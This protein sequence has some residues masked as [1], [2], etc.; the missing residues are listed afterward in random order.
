MSLNGLKK[1]I[2]FASL[3]GK[4]LIDAL[5]NDAATANGRTVSAALEYH[6]LYEPLLPQNKN[7]ASWI[8]MMYQDQKSIG[9]VI[10]ECMSFFAANPRNCSVNDFA[11]IL[12][13]CRFWG[14]DTETKLPD[15]YALSY[16]NT[17][18]D[19]LVEFMQQTAETTDDIY[20]KTDLLRE[21]K[22]M[23]KL[24]TDATEQM[25]EAGVTI[26]SLYFFEVLSA[27][28]S[29]SKCNRTYRLMAWLAKHCCW[30]DT[31]KS[32]YAL[33]QILKCISRDWER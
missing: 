1:T 33:I 31:A 22:R 23:K 17:Q 12:Q 5:L 4:K 29:L 3:E 14:G 19:C 10:T 28:P 18:V 15:Q 2:V 26:D 13:F 9:S 30:R 8:I 20:L 24:I 6:L 16:L 27:F 32:R 21:A 25:S 11:T 7:A